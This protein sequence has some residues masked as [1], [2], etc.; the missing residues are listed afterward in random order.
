MCIQTNQNRW[1]AVKSNEEAHGHAHVRPPSPSLA[2]PSSSITFTHLR[3]AANTC[4][5]YAKTGLGSDLLGIPT[6]L[7]E[8]YAS[9][10]V[11]ICA[12][13]E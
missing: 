11:C 10:S 8:W 13:D 7:S 9:S 2:Y 12:S 1:Y 6:A 5:T 3:P 4:I